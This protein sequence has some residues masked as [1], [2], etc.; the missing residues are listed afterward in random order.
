MGRM[1]RMAGYVNSN[2]PLRELL[3]QISAKWNEADESG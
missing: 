2:P 3:K 1:H